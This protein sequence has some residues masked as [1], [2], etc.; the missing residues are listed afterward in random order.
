[1]KNIALMLVVVALLAMGAAAQTVNAPQ[2]NLG[3][4]FLGS[5]VYGSTSAVDSVFSYGFSTNLQLEGDMIA[6]PSGGVSDYLAGANY[7]L[8]GI[9]SLENILAPTAFSCGKAQPFLAVVGGAGRVQIGDSPLQTAPALMVKLGI[10]LPSASGAYTPSFVVGYGDFGPSIVGQSN[11]GF[12]GNLGFSFGVG[13]SEAA[14]QA[15]VA[16]KQFAEAK[17]MRKLQH[18]AEA[19]A[20][21]AREVQ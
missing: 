1:M 19:A 10:N 21:A 11:K 14:T 3:I 9:K 13:S 15:K 2:Y 18:K 12:F 5:G 16:R 6:A 8:C 17:K 4:N 7:D 20:K